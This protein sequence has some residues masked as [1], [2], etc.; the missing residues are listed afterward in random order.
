MKDIENTKSKGV[1]EPKAVSDA[2]K[3]YRNDSD[4]LGRFMEECCT[5]S[6]SSIS[7]KDFFV[8]Y[9]SWCNTNSEDKQF[10][11]SNGLT[12]ELKRKGFKIRS[13]HAGKSFLFGFELDQREGPTTEEL[14]DF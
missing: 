7:T 10:N 4:T 13:G 9:Q 1:E 8:A 11:R 2:I 12:K 6:N 5:A 14:D 3:E